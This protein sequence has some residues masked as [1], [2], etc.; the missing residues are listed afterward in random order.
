MTRHEKKLW[1]DFLS[2]YP[3]RFQR[4][5]A[6]GN[7]IADFYC[8]RAALVIE[9][10]GSGHFSPEAIEHDKIRTAELENLGVT[11]IRI[12]NEDIIRNFDGVRERIH[13][14]VSERLIDD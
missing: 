5:K 3:V 6:I 7:Y 10:D 12:F 8:A 2:N 4:Q 1:Y 14:V 13:T 9:L 11:V